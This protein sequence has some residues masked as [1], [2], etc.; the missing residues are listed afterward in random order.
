MYIHINVI[1]SLTL[2]PYN[3]ISKTLPCRPRK[4]RMQQ[5]TDKFKLKNN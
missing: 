1:E 4:Q 3:F 5:R 2:K